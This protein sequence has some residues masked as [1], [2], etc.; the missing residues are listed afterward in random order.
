MIQTPAKYERPATH[1]PFHL[2]NIYSHRWTP[3][4]IPLYPPVHLRCIVTILI[5]RLWRSNT[6]NNKAATSPNTPRMRIVTARRPTVQHSSKVWSLQTPN[7]GVHCALRVRIC[8]LMATSMEYLT[9]AFLDSSIVLLSR[10]R[11]PHPASLNLRC[12]RSLHANDA[13][14]DLDKEDYSPLAIG[15]LRYV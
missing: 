10:R 13:V 5:L 2:P 11:S 12:P 7:N 14:F 3:L 1:I 9:V 4:H 6:W 15:F 8:I